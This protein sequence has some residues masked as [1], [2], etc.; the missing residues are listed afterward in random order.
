MK[1]KKEE[2]SQYIN[3]K[4]KATKIMKNELNFKNIFL[5]TATISSVITVFIALIYGVF[6]IHAENITLNGDSTSG[7]TASATI[8]LVG[9][10]GTVF[11][12]AVIALYVLAGK[13]IFESIAVFRNE[14]IDD[15]Q[16]HV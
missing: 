10:F 2:Q 4:L 11:Y 5:Y 8:L 7:W 6:D 15:K 3:Y 14:D 16:S 9:S 13:K 1:R 12:S